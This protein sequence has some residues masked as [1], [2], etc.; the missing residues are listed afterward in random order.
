MKM[1][2]TYTNNENK[3]SLATSKSFIKANSQNE[4]EQAFR[5]W[6]ADTFTVARETFC[7]DDDDD[8]LLEVALSLGSEAL[9]PSTV[10]IIEVDPQ[11]I[12]KSLHK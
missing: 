9:T 11:P 5:K 7:L 4:V 2:K 8:T 6:A 12:A 10:R 3:K 1:N